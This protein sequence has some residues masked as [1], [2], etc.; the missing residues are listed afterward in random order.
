MASVYGNGTLTID[1][2]TFSGNV[3]GNGG[4][5]YLGGAVTI[6]ASTFTGNSASSNDGGA[7][8]ANSGTMMIENS[9][10]SGN[11]ASPTAAAW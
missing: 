8:F 10:I 9:T 5:L 4:A 11:S 6:R 2:S 1:R 3:A 7:I